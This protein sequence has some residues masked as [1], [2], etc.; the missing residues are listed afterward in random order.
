[1]E[2][3]Y[4]HQFHWRKCWRHHHHHRWFYQM[5]FIHQVEYRV[6]DRI[7]PSMHYRLGYLL[8]LHELK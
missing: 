8:I 1:L 7:I 3:V 2:R 5:A 6:Q 4:Q